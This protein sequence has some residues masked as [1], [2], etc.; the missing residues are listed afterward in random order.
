MVGE[1]VKQLEERAHGKLLAVLE[2]VNV[3]VNER[4]NKLCKL[5]AVAVGVVWSGAVRCG[6]V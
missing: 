4:R 3:Q 1:L 5:H 6:V 2:S